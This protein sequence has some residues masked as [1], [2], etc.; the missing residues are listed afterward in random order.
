MNTSVA[1]V[2][3]T[4]SALVGGAACSWSP[5]LLRSG[6]KLAGSPGSAVF[7]DET[8]NEIIARLSLSHR[9]GELVRSVFNDRTEF[10][11]AAD[12]GISSHTVHT[13]F[14]RLHKK[15]RVED[16]VQLVLCIT[17]EFLRLGAPSN[18]LYPSLV[19]HGPAGRVQAAA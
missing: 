17:Q 13:H 18:G 6:T 5:A 7:S 15:L 12:L 14:E 9:E 11:I 8:W 3:R 1:P 4:P 2:H 19:A 10:A 16:R